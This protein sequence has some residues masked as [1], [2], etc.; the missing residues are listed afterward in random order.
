MEEIILGFQL[1]VNPSC[2][3]VI[4]WPEERRKK[5]LLKQDIVFPLSVDESVWP[6]VENERVEAQL[7]VD[8]SS[9]AN[10][11]P[12]GL[13]LYQ[14]QHK[15][16]QSGFPA[17][18]IEAGW[19]IGIFAEKDFAGYLMELHG[20]KLTVPSLSVVALQRLGWCFLGY[21]VADQWLFSGLSACGFKGDEYADLQNTFASSLNKYGLFNEIKPALKFCGERNRS[22]PEHA[23]FQPIGI[24]SYHN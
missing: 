8:Y 13:G 2:A 17:S 9:D 15:Y 19:L 20:I 12:N 22:V 16:F 1:R 14:I 10:Y 18:M 4:D 24:V 7:F 6:S 21:D 11:S 3:V 23:P 5:F